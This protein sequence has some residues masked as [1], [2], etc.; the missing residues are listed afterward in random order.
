MS[1]FL[2][3][4]SKKKAK[5]MQ[6]AAQCS[7]CGECDGYC[8]R[9]YA[10][11]LQ[12][13]KSQ[14]AA[15][16]QETAA[17]FKK[18]AAVFKVG[19]LLDCNQCGQCSGYC[20]RVY[21]ASV[22]A[23]H[24]EHAYL[25]A[26]KSEEMAVDSL[27]VSASAKVNK[28]FDTSDQDSP[29]VS[30]MEEECIQCGQC[31]GYCASVYAKP[32]EEEC[33]LC[34]QCNRY[35]AGAYAE[36]VTAAQKVSDVLEM[37]EDDVSTRDSD[38]EAESCPDATDYQCSQ[39]GECS[40]YC[41]RAY[42]E[43]VKAAHTEGASLRKPK[44]PEIAAESQKVPA[45]L[46][47]KN[48]WFMRSTRSFF[49]ASGRCLGSEM[50]KM[51]EEEVSTKDSDSEAES[52]PDATEYQCSQCGE[53]SG[54]CARAYTESV[55][56][57]QTEHASLRKRKFQE[58]TVD[59]HEVSPALKVKVFDMHDV[60]MM[61]SVMETQCLVEDSYP[62]PE[63]TGYH[64]SQCGE[65]NGYCARVYP[66]ALKASQSE[67]AT[68]SEPKIQTMTV[69]SQELLAKLKVKTSTEKS[70]DDIRTKDSETEEDG[71]P[72]ASEYVCIQ[73]GDCNGYCAKAYPLLECK[74]A[75]AAMTDSFPAGP[76]SKFKSFSGEGWQAQ[77]W[78]A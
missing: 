6:P 30:E 61:G 45:A 13:A 39:C 46:K 41:A 53:C 12:Q 67:H 14:H 34:G 44:V 35:C 21:P 10:K 19:N 1:L 26:A 72:D 77:G 23:A 50:F 25:H 3:Q 66:E 78:R 73:C 65:C 56:A 43:S 28:L 4:P 18:E 7:L 51:S 54:Y 29:T 27:E 20:A 15:L 55:K 64:C 9:V 57:A 63:Y 11:A 71:C 5:I 31:N 17:D 33:T 38:S 70:E 2:E 16:V 47:V 62:E 52:C 74:E 22:Q 58:V 60:G 59:S 40:G 49:K 36:P 68:V 69:N 48:G 76:F 32:G 75:D 8:A 42:T 37:S 24:T